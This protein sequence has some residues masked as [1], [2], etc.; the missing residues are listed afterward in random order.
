MTKKVTA[1]EISALMDGELDEARRTEV[2]D[3]IAEDDELRDLWRRYHLT[4]GT[5]RGSCYPLGNRIL[6]EVISAVKEK[7]KSKDKEKLDD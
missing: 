6:A 7:N 3:A 2:I 4:R 1:E 5:L